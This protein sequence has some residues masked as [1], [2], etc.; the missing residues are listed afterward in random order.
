M[1]DPSAGPR[2]QIPEAV[3]IALT[4]TWV[5]PYCPAEHPTA[6]EITHGLRT[7]DD[8]GIYWSALD[9]DAEE[10]LADVIVHLW[11]HPESLVA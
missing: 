8:Q 10:D 7:G 3:G 9:T 6:I 11:T 2:L 4:L 5:C 1:P